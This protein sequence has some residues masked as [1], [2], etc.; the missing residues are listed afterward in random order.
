MYASP[1]AI[2]SAF[3]Q[4]YAEGRKEKSKPKQVSFKEEV[5]RRLGAQHMTELCY[6]MLDNVTVQRSDYVTHE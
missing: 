4:L 5:V 2:V 6:L 1:L 3:Q